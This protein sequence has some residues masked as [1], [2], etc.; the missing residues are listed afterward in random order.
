MVLFQLAVIA[1]GFLFLTKSSEEAIKRLVRLARHF[2][3]TEFAISFLVVGIVAIF[4]ELSIGINSALAGESSFGLGI[5]L[6]SN[7]AD[8]TLIVGVI[9]LTA[10]GIK[11]HKQTLAN[12][13]Y[14]LIPL[15]LPMALLWDGR[16]S[17]FDGFI[18]IMA[19]AA[20][21]A[22]FLSQRPAHPAKE[23]KARN[24]RYILKEVAVLAVSLVI[25]LGSGKIITDA[26]HELSLALSL[27]LMFIGMVLAI[28]TCLP[29]LSVAFRASQQNHG[30]L[31]LGNIFGNVLAD[32]ML[33]LGVI[34]VISPI[35]PQ[36][37]LL[38]ITSGVASILAVLLILW[39]LSRKGEKNTLSQKDGIILVA[40]YASYLGVQTILENAL[41]G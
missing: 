1:I 32:C 8:L 16:L 15:A 40:F 3:V 21:V 12:M 33:T 10:G 14:F 5:V 22:I 27:P 4:P 25:L 7:V 31:G 6:G 37:P 13:K 26:S 24:W 28:G 39:L 30:E 36:Y 35:K 41:V 18:L 19:F 2:E 17:Q 29:E 34:A 9:A 11:L 20:Y 23:K 38:A